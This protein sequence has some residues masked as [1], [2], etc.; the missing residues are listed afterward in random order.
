MFLALAYLHERDIIYW[1]LKPENVLIDGD[2]YV[3]ITDFGL[4]KTN[5]KSDTDAESFCGT[6]EYLAPEVLLRKG[7]GKSVDWWSFGS[8]IFEM[9]TGTPPF[10][11]Q[12]RETLFKLIWGSDPEWPQDVSEPCVDLLKGLLTKDPT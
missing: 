2:G 1:D 3:K 5:V 9:L 7:Y 4:S 11:E 6:P 8:I 12:N 10:Y